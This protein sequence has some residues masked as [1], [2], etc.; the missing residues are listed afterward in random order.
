MFSALQN[1]KDENVLDMERINVNSFDC[2]AKLIV[3]SI[4]VNLNGPN[5]YMKSGM[6]DKTLKPFTTGDTW[7]YNDSKIIDFS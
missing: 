2:I 1:N 4:T 5:I 6:V 7:K 3:Y